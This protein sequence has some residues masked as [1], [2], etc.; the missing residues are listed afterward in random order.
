M[1]AGVRAF[2]GQP[3][4]VVPA[5]GPPPCS[6]ALLLTRKPRLT[7]PYASGKHMPGGL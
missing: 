1:T 6:C 2:P 3:R 5:K 4:K 7:E